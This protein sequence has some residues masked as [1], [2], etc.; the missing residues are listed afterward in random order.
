MLVGNSLTANQDRAHFSLWAML[1]APLIAGNDLHQM[2]E[3]VKAV[4]TL[5][6]GH[7][8]QPGRAR[9]FQGLAMQP[10]TALRPGSNPGRR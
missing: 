4:L 10:R 3:S 6:R 5:T 8:H 7:C 9:H 2:P 1:A